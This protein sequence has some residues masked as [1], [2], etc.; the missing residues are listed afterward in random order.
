MSE[1][2]KTQEKKTTLVNFILDKSG[3]MESVVDS[4]I[5]GF[6]EYIGKLKNDGNSYEFSLTF[7][8]TEVVKKYVATPIRNVDSLNKDNYQPMGGTALYDAVCS[9]VRSIERDL[10]EGVKVLNVILTDGEENASRLHTERDFSDMVKRLEGKGN[11]TFVF[12]GANQDSWA[13][14]SKWGFAMNNVSNFHSTAAGMGGTFNMLASNTSAFA[15]SATASTR[16]FMSDEDK[17]M[18][19]ATK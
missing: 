2:L 15:S 14:A 19:E 1:T 6:N 7:F 10:V 11:W 12:L 5:S 16:S 3:S 8:D 4:T 17:A 13:R 9:T 18:L